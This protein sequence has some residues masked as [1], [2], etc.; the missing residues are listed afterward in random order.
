[1]SQ[2]TLALPRRGVLE[3]SRSRVNPLWAFMAMVIMA[4]VAVM[5]TVSAAHASSEGSSQAQNNLSTEVHTVISSN[6]YELD[7]GGYAKGSQLLVQNQEGFY[8]IDQDEF[9]KLNGDGRNDL[10]SD[11]VTATNNAV[12]NGS[13]TGVTQETAASWL[14]NLQKNPGFGSK[15]LQE[16]LKNTGPDFITANNIYQPFSGLVST[17]LGLGAILIFALLGLVI[18]ADIAYITIPPFRMITGDGGDGDKRSKIITTEAINAVETA[19]N[20]GGDGKQKSALGQYL[21]TRIVA[22]VILAICLVYLIQGQIYV[23]IG[24]ILDAFNGFLGF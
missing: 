14:K 16:T 24:W 19:E 23:L 9:K 21:K 6:D 8:D 17:L 18:V 1:M 13:N 11:I 10:A 7:G 5:G 12:E 4:L 15:I 3:G 20:S 2:N 22:M